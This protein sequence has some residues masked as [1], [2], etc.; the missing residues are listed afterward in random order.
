MTLVEKYR[1]L[2]DDSRLK[3]LAALREGPFNVQE[4]TFILG[5]SQ[6]TV[7]HH[8]KVLERA[9]MVEA[10]REGTWSYYSLAAGGSSPSAAARVLDGA[11]ELFEQEGLTNGAQSL[12]VRDVLASRSESSL[13]Y[14]EQVNPEAEDK[15]GVSGVGR[16]P[17]DDLR[18]AIPLE[19]VLADLGCGAGLLLKGLLP[20]QGK[21]IGVD[22]SRKML[23]QASRYLS[24]FE[25]S[26]E[27]K[28]GSLESLPL[29]DQSIDV[30]LLSMVLHHVAQPERA[31]AEVRRVLTPGG[32]FVLVDLVAHGNENFRQQ[33]SDLWLGFELER[34]VDLVRSAGF[35]VAA[36][37]T[38]DGSPASFLLWATREG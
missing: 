30:A 27:L 2:A 7:S 19:G 3:L 37:Q 31:L 14:F 4:L 13:R 18:R 34:I 36:P 16:V 29:G 1:A 23:S 33:F 21:T 25:D 35:T 22:Y 6:P 32:R 15:L 11:L 10:R 26:C 8:L 5:L 28:Q 24:A 38:Y 9:G 20:R 17:F 12:R